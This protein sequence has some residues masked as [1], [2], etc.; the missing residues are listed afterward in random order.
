M[1]ASSLKQYPNTQKVQKN[2]IYLI[3]RAY[4]DMWIF[5]AIPFIK[6]QNDT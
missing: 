2:A 4:Q 1:T 6:L 3:I 5:G